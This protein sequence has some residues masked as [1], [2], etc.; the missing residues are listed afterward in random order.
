ML[1]SSRTA[2]GL[3]AGELEGNETRD[4]LVLPWDELVSFALGFWDQEEIEAAL[5]ND[6]AT[7]IPELLRL[8]DL[9][10][11]AAER[12]ARRGHEGLSRGPLVL[13]CPRPLG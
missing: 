11:R 7:A 3:K 9:Q 13:A 10:V 5:G 2:F 6:L 1:G 12:R 4:G 8:A